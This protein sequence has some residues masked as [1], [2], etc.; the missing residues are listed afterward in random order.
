[1]N[2][3][4]MII[5]IHDQLGKPT[6]LR[7]Y[8]DD[9]ETV[10]IGS[11]GAQKILGWLNRGYRRILTWRLRGGRIV[12]FG[13]TEKQLYFSSVVVDGTAAAGAAQSIT[14]PAAVS[15][16]ADRYKKWSIKITGGT[17]AGQRRIIVAYSTARVATVH[18]AW[19]TAPD[20]TSTFE[21]TKNFSYYL[22]AGNAIVSDHIAVN[23]SSGIMAIM[24]I[25]DMSTGSVLGRADRTQ[26]FTKVELGNG[27]PSVYQDASEGLWFNT[28]IPDERYYAVRYHG[29]PD[30]LDALD[31]EPAIPVQFHEAVLLWAIWWG[32]RRA[33]EFSGAYSTKRDLEDFMETAV[34]QYDR[35]TDREDI[36]LYLEEYY[37]P[38]V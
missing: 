22:D 29:F 6:D 16:I 10:D 35:S 36:S 21:L 32:L 34:Q 20:A 25:V 13:T 8:A 24:K 19:D 1:M 28:A 23:P 26:D 11:A 3:E 4:E 18:K 31:D 2:I 38:S 7:P 9:G 27:A 5:E 30:E 15:D 14:F 17:G 33:Q 12:R 37:G